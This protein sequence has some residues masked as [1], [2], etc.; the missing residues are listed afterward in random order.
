MKAWDGTTI[1]PAYLETGKG[2]RRDQLRG[3]RYRN[4]EHVLYIGSANQ[5]KATTLRCTFGLGAFTSTDVLPW[6]II[7]SI[8]QCY[9]K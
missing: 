6:S 3:I 4:R 7:G 9:A 2:G 5:G 1:P 8:L